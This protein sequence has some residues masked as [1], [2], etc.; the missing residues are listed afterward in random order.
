M[1]QNMSAHRGKFIV[2]LRV[3][4]KKQEKSGLGLEAQRAAVATWLNGGNWTVIEEIIEVESGKRDKNRP[5]LQLA[6]D[7]CKRYGAKLVIA[8]LD[9]LSRD[10][11][12]LLSL[13]DAG[14][15]FVCCDNPTA[16]RLTIG[17]L[18]MV[19]EQER[20]ALGQRTREALAQKKLQGAKLGNPRPE[21]WHFN[22]RKTAKAAGIKGGAAVRQSADT[23]AE[24]IKPLLVGELVDLS[25]NATA[26]E[27]NRRGVK[28]ARGGSWT[29]RSVLNLKERL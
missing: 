7:A 13:R 16:N 6:L 5:A 2:Y 14:V 18:A 4:T 25:A 26:I 27:L 22:D 24:L 15:T 9:R 28:T 10:P 21:K 17:I 3:S 29:A 11:V 20:E 12:F 23:F 8:K 1:E 19:A